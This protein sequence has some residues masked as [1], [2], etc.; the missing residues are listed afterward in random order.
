MTIAMEYDPDRLPIPMTSR[1]PDQILLFRIDWASTPA[2][3]LIGYLVSLSAERSFG[4]D[5]VIFDDSD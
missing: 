5:E 3:V 1:S 4:I 2:G